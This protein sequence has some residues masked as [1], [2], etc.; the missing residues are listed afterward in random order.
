[1]TVTDLIGQLP[2]HP[3]QRYHVRPI[4]R[5][6]QYVLHHTA[7][8]RRDRAMSQQTV[9]A[10][11]RFHVTSDYLYV[12]GA[13]GIAYHYVVGPDGAVYKCWPASTIAACVKKQNTRSLCVA[14]IGNFL[15]E[16][17]TAAQWAA[18]VELFQDLIRAYDP[19]PILS[20][21]EALPGYTQCP[22][23]IDMQAFR[24]D[25]KGG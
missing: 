4:S 15:V 14:M 19:A 25:V 6:D 23:R 13:P 10:I 2:V 11:A 16:L 1:M 12:G 9:E 7:G 20:H 21:G 8:R 24:D 5:I 22:G 17:P 18:T 3:T